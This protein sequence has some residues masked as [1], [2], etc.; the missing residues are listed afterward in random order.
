MAWLTA[1]RRLAC[2]YE[3]DPAVFDAMICWAAINTMPAVSAAADDQPSAGGA[4]RS[5]RAA[6]PSQHAP[7]PDWLNGESG[8]V[9]RAE[10][11][12]ESR[13][14]SSSEWWMRRS[15]FELGPRSVRS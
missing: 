5:R 12:Q 4:G 7:G 8:L 6:D 10:S 2:D 3:R 15:P 13:R 9:R 11:S 14:L 1:R